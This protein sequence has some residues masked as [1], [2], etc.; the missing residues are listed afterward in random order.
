MSELMI[1]YAPYLFLLVMVVSMAIGWFLSG[2]HGRKN[3]DR[4]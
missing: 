4:S 1:E 2:R 3:N